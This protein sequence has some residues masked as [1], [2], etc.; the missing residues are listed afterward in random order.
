M[1]VEK[2]KKIEIL[3]K[4]ELNKKD[5]ELQN[6]NEVVKMMQHENDKLT[7]ENFQ[8]RKEKS[9]VKLKPV[10]NE[11]D[12]ELNILKHNVLLLEEDK[13]T[14]KKKMERGKDII[15]NK[16]QQ[17][18]SMVQLLQIV[19]QQRSLFQMHIQPNENLNDKYKDLKDNETK[20]LVELQKIVEEQLSDSELEYEG[21]SDEIEN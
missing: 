4:D 7:E 13:N 3:L 10:K 19:K 9:L 11:L 8:L 15:T 2:L 6:A 20:V 17:N 1:N 16:S 21:D 14:L 18:T 12:S 5:G